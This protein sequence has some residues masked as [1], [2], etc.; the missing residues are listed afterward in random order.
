MPRNWNMFI[1]LGLSASV[2]YAANVDADDVLEVMYHERPPY[3][4]GKSDNMIGG[5]IG[6]AATDILAKAGIEYRFRRVPASRQLN[7]IKL[8]RKKACALGWFKTAKRE[9]F[10]KYSIAIYRDKPM[11]L[12]V[13]SSDPKIPANIS[14]ARLTK[15]PQL[16]MGAKLGYSYGSVIDDLK[17]ALEPN[18]VTATQDSTG[19]MRMLAGKR[20]DYFFAAAEEASEIVAQSNGKVEALT[21]EDS[22]EGNERYIICTAKVSDSVI[23]RIN[24]AIEK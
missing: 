22:P 3:Y 9:T 4:V 19:L 18:V 15:S 14:L 2:L 20:F 21:L 7:E 11:V 8:D 10:A 17:A 24:N 23:Q 12:M 5:V 6:D 16:R 13:R 1:A